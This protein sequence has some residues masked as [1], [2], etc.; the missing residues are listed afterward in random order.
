MEKKLSDYFKFLVGCECIKDGKVYI[1]T[2]FSVPYSTT[3]TT[4]FNYQLRP[5]GKGFRSTEY[6]T[7]PERFKPLLRP[8][9]NITHIEVASLIGVYD[10]AIEKAN[11]E[12]PFFQIQYR[13][14][15]NEQQFKHAYLSQLSPEQFLFLLSKGFDLFGLIDAG[16]ALIKNKYNGRPKL[17]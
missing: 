12:S 14:E 17:A 7:S 8:L 11:Y 9:S 13:D 15:N 5:K 10:L 4:L 16:L 1:F 2:G 3:D 6:L